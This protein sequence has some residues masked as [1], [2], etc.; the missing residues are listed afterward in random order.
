MFF[1]IYNIKILHMK[2]KSTGVSDENAYL[3]FESIQRD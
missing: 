1:S 2:G 3:G